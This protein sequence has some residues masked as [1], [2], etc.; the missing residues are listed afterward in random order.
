MTR[1]YR[2]L[3]RLYPRSFREEYA[4]E[5]TRTY[6]AGIRDRGGISAALGALTDVVPNALAAHWTILVQDLHYAARSLGGSRGFAVATILVTALGVGA[7]TATFSV[8]DF[9]L[10]RPLAFPRPEEIVRICQGPRSGGGWGCM[11]ELSPANYRDL[12]AISRSFASMGA[13]TGGARNLVGAGEPIRVS[14]EMLTPEVL[15]LLGVRPLLGRFFDHEANPQDE[16]TAVIGYGLWQ[17]Q[18]GGDP[19][20]VGRTISLDGTPHVVIGVMP[21]HFRWPREDVQL[22]TPFLMREANVENRNNTYLQGIARLKPGLTFEQARQE[23]SSIADRMTREVGG[24][25]DEGEVGFSFFKQRDEMSPRYRTMLLALCG[26]SLAL[27][28]LTCANLANLLLARSASRERELAVR[29]ALGAGRERLMR[30]MLTESMLLALLGGIAG[31]ALAWLTVPLLAQMVPNTLPMASQPALDMRA[32]G[33]A[34]VL[35]ALTGLGFGLVPALRV[36]GR[37]GLAALREGARGSVRRKGLRTLLVAIEVTVSVILLIAS[38]LL[39]RAVWRV[40]AIDPGFSAANVLTMSTALPMPRYSDVVP[41]VQFYDRV[42]SQVR[43]LPGVES[44]AYTSGVPMVM[45]GGITR[46]AIPGVEVRPDDNTASIRVV[47]SQ[48]FRTLR[49]PMQRGRDIS[50]GD[51]RDRQH[52]AVVSES[53]VQRY[54]PNTDA[55]G[56]TFQTRNRTWSV[57]GVVRDIKVRGLERTNEPQ[58]YVPAAQADSILGIYTPKD[59][60]IRSSRD[61]ASLIGPVREIIRGA[62]PQQP[63][64][65]V[66][67]LTDVVGDQTLTRRSQVRILVALAVLALVLA[68]V[69]IHGLLAFT[70]AQRDREIGVRLALGADPA[71]VARMVVG[72]GVRMALIGVVPGIGIAYLAARAMQSLLFGVPAADPLTFLVVALL[73]FAAVVIACVRPAWRAARIEPIAVLRAD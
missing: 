63:I 46:I 32:F 41:R 51:T 30:Q 25:M 62:D 21:S 35:S 1:F 52:V 4:A 20:V 44:A 42:L 33:I 23:L 59:L 5:L 37:T 57:I 31:A 26:A 34:V 70:V 61:A 10:L 45:T 19:D 68:A 2:A 3:L 15:P 50:E 47:S 65:N 73:C 6:E 54:W 55:I 58:M 64:S 18:F 11:N 66:R 16:Q 17:T 36:G 28:L 14:G 13:Y 7:N 60:V 43:A 38:G 71:G 49:V 22:W 39:I 40:Q 12:K 72:E 53:F 27:L 69:G 8:A 56:Q 67:M 48:L 29:A 24:E 9:V